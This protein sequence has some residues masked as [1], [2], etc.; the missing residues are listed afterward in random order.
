MEARPACLLLELDQTAEEREFSS[1][2]ARHYGAIIRREPLV[3][4]LM[5]IRPASFSEDI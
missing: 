3:S 2:R 4:I 1:Y 5:Q